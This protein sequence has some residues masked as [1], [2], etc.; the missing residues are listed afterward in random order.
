MEILLCKKGVYMEGRFQ[1]YEGY[2]AKV[3]NLRLHRKYM[4]NYN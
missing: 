4:Q 3:E 1:K 2:F